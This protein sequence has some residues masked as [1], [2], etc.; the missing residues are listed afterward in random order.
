MAVLGYKSAIIGFD[1]QFEHQQG[2]YADIDQVERALYLGK[3]EG[4][5]SAKTRKANLELNCI[6]AIERMALS[7]I[8]I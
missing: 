8:H 6:A 7:L 5:N 1:A 4:G 2:S 3:N